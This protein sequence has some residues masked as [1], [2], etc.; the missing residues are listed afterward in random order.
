MATTRPPSQDAAS[1]DHARLAKRVKLP[2][3]VAP[4]MGNPS[5]ERWAQL[6]TEHLEVHAGSRGQPK[7]ASATLMDL[8]VLHNRIN[9]L[10]TDVAKLSRRAASRVLQPGE[11]LEDVDALNEALFAL[12]QDLQ[13]LA[14]DVSASSAVN[15]NRHSSTTDAL[16]ALAQ[17][18]NALERDVRSLQGLVMSGGGTSGDSASASE[19]DEYYDDGEPGGAAFVQRGVTEAGLVAGL[20]AQWTTLLSTSRGLL[21]GIGVVSQEKEGEAASA[22]VVQ[23]EVFSV[24]S[25]AYVPE[26]ADIPNE[27]DTLLSIS[28]AGVEF[29]VPAFF[30]WPTIMPSQHVAQ[31]NV[32]ATGTRDVHIEL[33][34]SGAAT[35]QHVQG[36]PFIVDTGHATDPQHWALAG[37]LMA[38][39][40]APAVAPVLTNGPASGPA[41]RVAIHA[42]ALMSNEWS[43]TGGDSGGVGR[44]LVRCT[45]VIMLLEPA[46][47]VEI[48]SVAWT[49]YSTG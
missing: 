46:D 48:R 17:R 22:V 27:D 7:T 32:W 24:V 8:E 47:K 6:V 45:P 18:V 15:N 2:G 37:P 1:W 36:E 31:R 20:R 28:A 4:Q 10:G 43:A 14:G 19:V 5:A 25:P 38:A 21:A 33:D 34:T 42:E 35:G 23:G 9:L 26:L 13:T 41:L 39:R 40:A 12:D 49:L 11:K 30:A 3:L 16:A 44:V 29:N